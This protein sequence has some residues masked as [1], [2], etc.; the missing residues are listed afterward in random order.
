[1]KKD[2]FELRDILAF[3]ILFAYDI[4]CHNKVAAAI[5]IKTKPASGI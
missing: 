1:V 2:T 5:A 3:S 4:M